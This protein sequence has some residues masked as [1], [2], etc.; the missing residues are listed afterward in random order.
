[1]VFGPK[2]KE[3][4]RKRVSFDEMILEFLVA[5]TFHRKTCS[6]YMDYLA[7]ICMIFANVQSLTAGYESFKEDMVLEKDKHV[8]PSKV[9][10]MAA[11]PLEQKVHRVVSAYQHIINGNYRTYSLG[12]G[13]VARDKE[14]QLQT[15]RFLVFHYWLS[16]RV[17]DEIKEMVEEKVYG[18]STTRNRKLRKKSET[19]NVPE[20][21]RANTKDRVVDTLLPSVM[22]EF[23]RS[24]SH[25]STTTNHSTPDGSTTTN[26]GL[27]F[28]DHQSVPPNSSRTSFSEM[29]EKK[30]IQGSTTIEPQEKL[31]TLNKLRFC[32]DHELRQRVSSQLFI[33]SGSQLYCLETSSLEVYC[34]TNLRKR[35]HWRQSHFFDR[36]NEYFSHSPGPLI[37]NTVVTYVPSL[38]GQYIDGA[39]DVLS[40][41][42]SFSDI[43]RR[44]ELVLKGD[45]M[46]LLRHCATCG[47]VDDSRRDGLFARV[48]D[49]GVKPELGTIYGKKFFATN[50]CYDIA[51]MNMI[52]QTLA[53]VVDFVWLTCAE[54]QKEAHVPPMGGNVTRRKKCGSKL[55]N[56]LGCC[57]S[58]FEAVTVACMLLSHNTGNCKPHTD[59]LNDSLYAYSKTGTLNTVM[60]DSNNN[61]HML[62]VICNFRKNGGSPFDPS[63]VIQNFRAYHQ[64]LQ[65]DYARAFASTTG[66]TFI[67]NPSDLSTF[68]LDKNVS[69]SMKRLS[70]NN[71]TRAEIISLTI[72]T[73]RTLSC[74]A[75]FHPVY[76][77]LKRFD[78]EQVTEIFFFASFLNTPLVFN[79]SFR[80]VFGCGET[81]SMVEGHPVF[82]LS[83]HMV[84]HFGTILAGDSARFSPANNTFQEM[85]CNPNT[86]E[87]AGSQL[88]KIV[89]VL[90]SWMC[91]IDDKKTFQTAKDV[92][93][94]TIDKRMGEILSD[95]KD[96]A[97]TQLDFSKFRLSLFTTFASGIGLLKPGLHLHQFFFP[98]KGTASY[99]HL[100]KPLGDRVC[101][102]SSLKNTEKDLSSSLLHTVDSNMETISNEMK[103]RDY[104]RDVVE[105]HLCESVANR[106]LN[107]KDVFFRGQNIFNLNDGKPVTKRFGCIGPWEELD[108]EHLADQKFKYVKQFEKEIVGKSKK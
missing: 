16:F 71:E 70:A 9:A 33:D 20:T 86:Y 50:E 41:A 35:K 82:A 40:V 19:S 24:T 87:K 73:S 46:A 13:R 105:V 53:N 30:A 47:E 37:A 26:P 42:R 12:T 28:I 90:H 45:L 92:P 48:M 83:K 39:N 91:F 51:E 65:R 69:H 10:T 66:G 77:N 80:Q 61:L 32:S 2:I 108:L 36:H 17:N 55:A 59:M 106:Y 63:A 97:G 98:T 4:S 95:I 56:L 67:R 44:N 107:K 85:F 88:K 103:W 18:R 54:M 81:S 27:T 34:A 62:Q 23:N 101:M 100:N 93:L 31:T 64:N 43:F 3:H 38:T 96:I 6:V 79:H 25:R 78:Y 74:S 15:I 99:K 68:F 29:H 57:S 84:D 102:P 8:I 21:D 52:R 72:G 76:E 89:R 49:F 14:K 22:L 5:S 58:E 7:N 94:W 75:Y 104:R 11:F 1:M 60:I